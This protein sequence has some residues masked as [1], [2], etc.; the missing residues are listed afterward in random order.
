MSITHAVFLVLAE[1]VTIGNGMLDA[2]VIM[3]ANAVGPMDA[4]ATLTVSGNELVGYVASSALI[5]SNFMSA[6]VD[7]LF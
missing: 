1:A 7:A 5:A 2:W 4:N 6:I 3:P